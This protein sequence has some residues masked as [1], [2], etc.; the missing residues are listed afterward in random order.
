M[1]WQMPQFLLNVNSGQPCRCSQIVEIFFMEV[2]FVTSENHPQFLLN[3]NSGQPCRCSQIV[4]IFFME[5]FFVTSENH[6]SKG[7]GQVIKGCH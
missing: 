4:E 5:V 7:L 3:V 1:T 6:P 2:F